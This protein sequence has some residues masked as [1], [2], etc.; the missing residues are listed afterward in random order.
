MFIILMMFQVLSSVD[1]VSPTPL[2]MARRETLSHKHQSGH[3]HTSPMKCHP[4]KSV[5]ALA[6]SR[7]EISRP[8]VRSN[9]VDQNAARIFAT[10]LIIKS[11]VF[12]R[13]TGQMS[14]GI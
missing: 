14:L 12:S 7:M 9:Y 4:A 11:V 2:R 5:T 6:G 10:L 13:R 1:R 3:L 8:V